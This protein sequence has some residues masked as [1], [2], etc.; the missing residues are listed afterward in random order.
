MPYQLVGE[1]DLWWEDLQKSLSEEQVAALTWNE[2]KEEFLEKFIPLSHRLQR[3]A[4]F[5]NLRQGKMS[6]SDYEKRFVTLAHSPG[7]YAD[8]DEKRA[9]YSLPPVCFGQVEL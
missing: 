2:F 3:E 8:T 9:R 1:A 5:H 4:E 7:N 6:V